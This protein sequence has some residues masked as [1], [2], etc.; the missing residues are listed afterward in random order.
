MLRNAYHCNRMLKLLASGSSETLLRTDLADR[1]RQI[2]PIVL[3]LEMLSSRHHSL[4]DAAAIAGEGDP[5]R[6]PLLLEL[7][8]NVLSQEKR[9]SITPL[10]EPLPVE[11]RDITGAQ[12]YSDL[13]AK[14]EPELQRALAVVDSSTIEGKPK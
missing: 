2:I 10:I 7:L 14:L 11:E 1:I 4:T 3:G 13:P 5:A 8:D 9:L 12:L 6:I